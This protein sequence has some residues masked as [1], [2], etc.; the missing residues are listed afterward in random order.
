MPTCRILL[1]VLAAISLGAVEADARTSP[2]PVA[3]KPPSP[4]DLRQRAAAS[5]ATAREIIR[6]FRLDPLG[7]AAQLPAA[8]AGLGEARDLSEQVGDTEAVCDLEAELLWCRRQLASEEVRSRIPA[9]GARQA[10][11]ASRRIEER[12]APPAQADEQLARAEAA[13]AERPEDHLQNALRFFAVAERFAG[14]PAAIKAQHLSLAAHEAFLRASQEAARRTLFAAPQIRAGT[15]PMPSGAQMRAQIADLKRAF[16]TAWSDQTTTGRRVLARRLYEEGLRRRA[17]PPA[18]AAMLTEAL[19]LAAESDEV[20]LIVLIPDHMMTVFAGYDAVG[21]RRAVLARLRSR[22]L[23]QAML[24]MGERPDDPAANGLVGRHLA[25]ELGRWEP[26]LPLLAK[27][28]DGEWARVARM[29]LA[30]PV[31]PAEQL[32]TAQAWRELARRAARSE[33][34]LSLGARARIWLERVQP[35][36]EGVQR[37]EADRAL[38]ELARDMPFDLRSGDYFG[39][40]PAQW[41]QFK[42]TVVAVPARPDR[43][44]AGVALKAGEQVRLVPHPQDTWSFEN[45]RRVPVI[46]NWRGPMAKNGERG[47]W[48]VEGLEPRRGDQPTGAVVAW[49]DARDPE[50]ITGVFSGPGRLFLSAN[51]LGVA[52]GA[53]GEIRVKVV[54]VREE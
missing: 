8:V 48:G 9:E 11:E 12:P 26:A 6:R 47:D 53:K 2:A 3:V 38:A 23:G 45:A 1:P 34:R 17:E 5:A 31:R 39:M 15:V 32:A 14:S 10:E 20:E 52:N 50:A 49:L 22:P 27:G 13:A 54:P 43:T 30:R 16:A 44:D 35:Q 46:C 41:D 25:L 19:R 40:S 7:I 37:E 42:G 29:E 28:E 51:K 33:D 4:A 18:F 24:A 36:L 21:E